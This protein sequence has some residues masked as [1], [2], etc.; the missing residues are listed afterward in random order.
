MIAGNWLD[1]LEYTVPA[2]SE[3]KLG[4]NIQDVRVDSALLLALDLE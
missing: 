4:H 1:W 3:M 2:Q